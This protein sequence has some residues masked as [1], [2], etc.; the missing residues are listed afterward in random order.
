MRELRLA[1]RGSPL[2]L[3]QARRVQARLA[4]LDPGLATSLVVVESGGDRRPD[5]PIHSLGGGGVFVAEI[6]KAV[7]AG[8]AEVAV[9]SLKDLPSTNPPQGLVLAATPERADVRDALV[10]RTL[11]QLGP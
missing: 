9:H 2:A 11:G 8:R 4:A 3:A 10:G 5:A 7:L 6:E 1:T